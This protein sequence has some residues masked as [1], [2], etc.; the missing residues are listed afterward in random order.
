M[1]NLIQGSTEWLE[2]R[3]G[4]I[5]SSQVAA[6]LGQSDFQTA[7]GLW[8]ELTGLR[9]PQENNWAMQRGTEAEPTIRSLY[10]LSYGYE[11][12]PALFQHP[13]IPYLRCSLDGWNAEKK[14][15]VEMKYPS[16]EKHGMALE[17]IIPAT[18]YPQVQY[19]LFVTSADLAHYVS[20]SG[21]DIAVVEVKPDFPYME[22]MI[23]KVVSFW[24]LVQ[25]KTPPPLTDRDYK[26]VRSFQMKEK[27]ERW[28]F[29][30]TQAD[31]LEKELAG[32]KEEIVGLCDHPRVRSYGVRIVRYPGNAGSV[33]Y[34]RMLEMLL[35]SAL[36]DSE[37]F[38][39]PA[40]RPFSKIE[41]ENEK[42]PA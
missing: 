37:K 18:Y 42:E 22:D 30:K 4:G 8:E 11:V 6:I 28:K 20:Y 32:L 16:G 25:S 29:V 1:Q 9:A 35:P 15:V 10:S 40:G 14:L 27:V 17:G 34:R 39:K 31:L 38:R 7:F 2:W 33:D 5:G 12:P 3:K 21:S 36:S 23:E 26:V 13:E 24:D 41:V 19:Q